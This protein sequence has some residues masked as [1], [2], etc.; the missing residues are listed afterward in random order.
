MGIVLGN[1]LGS[2][3]TPVCRDVDGC[4]AS[5]FWGCGFLRKGSFK[6]FARAAARFRVTRV[7]RV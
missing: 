7:F 2:I 4:R 1:F 3:R 6:G 5:G